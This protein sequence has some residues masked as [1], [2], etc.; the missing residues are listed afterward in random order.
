[1]AYSYKKGTTAMSNLEKMCNYSK[2]YGCSVEATLAVIGGRWKP[3]I[4]FQ[5]LGGRVLRFSKLRSQVP[6]ITQRMLTKQ[7]RDLERDGV[8]SRKI[9]P[10]VPPRVEYKLTA[11]GVTLKPI[12]LEMRNWGAIHMTKDTSTSNTA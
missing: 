9:Y 11:Y 2:P 8:V 6:G 5:L 3:V 7:L 12:L 1:L 10:E 4:L